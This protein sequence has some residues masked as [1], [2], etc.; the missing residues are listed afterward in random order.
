VFV[1]AKGGGAES[2]RQ[3][4]QQIEPEPESEPDEERPDDSER[5]HTQTS[6]LEH[7]Q[8]V[9]EDFPEHSCGRG[10]LHRVEEAVDRL[11]APAQGKQLGSKGKQLGLECK[12]S[13]SECKQLGL[14]GKQLG[15]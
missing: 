8:R 4:Q 3:S 10:A 14:E 1:A 5:P 12:I 9:L 13:G 11:L 15:S 2:R 6:H 7:F